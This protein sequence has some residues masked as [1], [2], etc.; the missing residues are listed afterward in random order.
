MSLVATKN[1][2]LRRFKLQKFEAPQ[3]P[4]PQQ[5]NTE[6]I[7]RQDIYNNLWNDL[8]HNSQLPDTEPRINYENLKTCTVQSVRPQVSKTTTVMLLNLT[9]TSA[10]TETVMRHLAK[11]MKPR[12]IIISKAFLER[13]ATELWLLK[14]KRFSPFFTILLEGESCTIP[15]V[16]DE[17]YPLNLDPYT[18]VCV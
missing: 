18:M 15:L 2:I 13:R 6:T 14:G 8:R 10:L 16:G 12:K 7:L 4:I 3:F 1:A 17:A 11:G 5:P 9:T